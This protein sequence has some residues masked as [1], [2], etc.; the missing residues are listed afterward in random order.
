MNDNDDGLCSEDFDDDR[1]KDY[2]PDDDYQ[3][4]IH[5]CFYS[6][7]DRS[8]SETLLFYIHQLCLLH[9][10]QVQVF[11]KMLSFHEGV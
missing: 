3:S 6:H 9:W 4:G 1:D 10:Y 2:V 8:E 5:Q 7:Q 11:T